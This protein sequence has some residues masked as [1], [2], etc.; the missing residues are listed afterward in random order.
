[1]ESRWSKVR[2]GI[3]GKSQEILLGKCFF[4]K[5]LLHSGFCY[6]NTGRRRFLSGE[7]NTLSVVRLFFLIQDFLKGII[8]LLE[9]LLGAL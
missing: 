1:M 8:T 7:D 9:R 2:K 4:D 5:P 3:L 6:R